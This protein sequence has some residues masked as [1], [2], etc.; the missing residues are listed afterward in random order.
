MLR[1]PSSRTGFP[2]SRSSCGESSSV[3]RTRVSNGIQQ[4]QRTRRDAAGHW[5]CCVN[6]FV[7][8]CD[9]D[10]TPDWLVMHEG[11]DSEHTAGDDMIADG[12]QEIKRVA[13]M[14]IR[15]LVTV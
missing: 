13:R 14:S 5:R 1:R 12:F 7:V 10:E 11:N 2:S 15:F 8:D 6:A 4:E 9:V 3:D